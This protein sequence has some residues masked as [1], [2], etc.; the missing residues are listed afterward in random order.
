MSDDCS[1]DISV[2]FNEADLPIHC[3]SN[4]E[5]DFT[6]SLQPSDP[7]AWKIVIAKD[8]LEIIYHNER[9]FATKLSGITN[10]LQLIVD[11]IN[12]TV[13]L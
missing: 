7:V 8:P 2:T 11:S 6:I 5:L 9:D 1:Y 13:T 4:N 10:V 3:N 12:R